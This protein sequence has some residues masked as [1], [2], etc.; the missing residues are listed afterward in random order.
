MPPGGFHEVI[1]PGLEFYDVFSLEDAGLSQEEMYKTTDSDGRIVVF[2]PDLTM[3]IARLTATRLQN[4][5]RPVRLFYTQP[6][7]R[8]DHGRTGRSHEITQAGVELL[9]AAGPAR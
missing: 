7:Y 8:N 4:Q 9:G 6:V 2:R 1:T 5:P 3:P